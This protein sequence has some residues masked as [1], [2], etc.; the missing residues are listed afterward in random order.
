[1]LK[2]A[3]CDD[4][5]EFLS[6]AMELIEKWAE[7]RDIPVE[8]YSFGNGDD[9]IAKAS[10]ERM[11]IVF[12]DIVMPLLNGMDTA[13]EL[14]QSDTSVMIVFLTSSPEFALES[15]EVKAQGYLL[16]PVSYEKMKQ[17]LDDCAEAF[18]KEPK[19]LVLKTAHG[20]RKIYYHDIEYVEAQNKKVIFFLRNGDKAEVSEPLY[21]FE[22][23]LTDSA[24]FFKCH[25][26]YLVNLLNADR[27]SNTDI[28][29][30][31]GRTVPIARGLAK[32]FKE[33][34]FALMFG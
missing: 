33:A 5:G 20:Y 11:D 16:K 18:E 17:T 13:R 7:H 3:V 25:R 34:Y 6:K 14:R 31:S 22:D 30:K 12:L 28:I 15:Y 10:S 9:L 29:T 2:I 32:A 26:S 23:R 1:M 4:N 19:N 24:G 8:L 21:A 27:F